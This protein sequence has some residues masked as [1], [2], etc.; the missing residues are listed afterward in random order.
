M[1][2][3]FYYVSSISSTKQILDQIASVIGKSDKYEFVK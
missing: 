2:K 3:H 1:L